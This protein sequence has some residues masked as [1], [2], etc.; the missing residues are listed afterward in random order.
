MSYLG[1][2]VKKKALTLSPSQVGRNEEE[3]RRERIEVEDDEER[4]RE[5]IELLLLQELVPTMALPIDTD[6]CTAKPTLFLPHQL[7]EKPNEEEVGIASLFLPHEIYNNKKYKNCEPIYDDHSTK[8]VQKICGATTGWV[9]MVDEESTSIT[10]VNTFGSR[11]VQIKLPQLSSSLGGGQQNTTGYVVHKA[12]MHL[13]PDEEDFSTKY[14]VMVTYGEGKQLAYCKE[15]HET[16]TSLAEYGSGYDD[17][18]CHDG[19]FYAVDGNGK[20]L[21]LQL[22][23][24]GSSNTSSPASMMQLPPEWFVWGQKAYFVSVGAMLCLVL[25]DFE[26]QQ[27]GPDWKTSF[28]RAFLLDFGQ[29]KEGLEVGDIGNWTILLGRHCTVAVRSWP[30]LRSNCVYFKD[31]C[32]SDDIYK[33]GHVRAFSFAERSVQE[34]EYGSHVWKNVWEELVLPVD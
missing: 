12:V 11:R 13:F 5:R 24:T 29:E 34:I 3:R 9:V 30:G 23:S 31:E 16:W 8:E 28:V 25:R 20:V 1:K 27:Y 22:V 18:I 32:P 4:R 14:V 10:L 6:S 17:I 15:G 21:R 19:E 33:V 26:Y 7:Y 2:E